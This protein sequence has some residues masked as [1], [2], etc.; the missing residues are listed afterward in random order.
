MMEI[1]MLNLTNFTSS[2]FLL[3]IDASWNANKLLGGAGFFIANTNNK[4]LIVGSRR[5][6]AESSLDVED[7]ALILG[8]NTTRD[9]NLWIKY[10][11]TDYVELMR[12]IHGRDSSHNQ[13]I[14]PKQVE[15]NRILQELGE[16]NVHIIPLEWNQLADHLAGHEKHLHVISS[17]HQGV[18]VVINNNIDNNNHLS[19]STI[20]V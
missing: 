19:P 10:I 7:K 8:L 2:Y 5:I 13:R 18:V 11:C 15:I 17:F 1:F 20:K 6:V 3:F 14:Q 12:S 9:L 4:I 16:I